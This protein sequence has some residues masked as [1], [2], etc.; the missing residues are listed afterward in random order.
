MG[1]GRVSI[2]AGS[3]LVFFV[4]FVFVSVGQVRAQPSPP[5]FNPNPPVAGEPFTVSGATLLGGQ[6]IRLYPRSTCTGSST[7]LGISGVIGVY[8]F[9]LTEAAGSYCFE[10]EGL[11]P[12]TVDPAPP[13]PSSYTPVTIGGMMLPINRLQILLPWIT[14]ILILGTVAAYSLTV[15]RKSTKRK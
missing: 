6:S 11:Y 13:T 9:T 1:L 3:S 7:S 8:S 5:M 15:G 4:V 10:A 14:L 2:V 12:F